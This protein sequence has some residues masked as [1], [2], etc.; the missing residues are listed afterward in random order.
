MTPTT[1]SSPA[2]ATAEIA[3]AVAGLTADIATH[4]ALN[5]THGSTRLAGVSSGTYSGNNTANR[6]IAHGLSKAP[7]LVIIYRSTGNYERISIIPGGYITYHS[8]AA[9]D[10]LPVTAP[11]ATNFYVGNAS[12]YSASANNTT[13]DY[14][15]VAIG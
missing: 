10:Q 12:S 6:A 9:I 7:Y 3:A 13:V 15:W 8:A 5:N 2:S 11:D 14:K 1:I 4:A